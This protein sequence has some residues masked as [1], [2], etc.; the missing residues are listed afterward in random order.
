M[1]NV[2]F[3]SPKGGSGKTT[4]ALLL[5]LGLAARGR[6]V[7]LID[8]DPNKRLLRWAALPGKPDEITV[9]AAPT[10]P[11]IRDALREAKRHHRA[12]GVPRPLRPW[13]RPGLARGARGL[14]RGRRAAAGKLSS[15][16]GET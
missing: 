10:M 4:A 15:R 8:S 3:V 9:H 13:R 16:G 1:P 11:D 2:A 12:G 7:A 6:R 14:W 5:A